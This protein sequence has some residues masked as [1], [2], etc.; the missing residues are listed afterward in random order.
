MEDVVRLLDH[1]KIEKAHV[2]GYSMGGMIT[3]KLLTRHPERVWSAVLG[4]MGWLRQGSPLQQVW[5]Q[6]PERQKAA[7]PSVCAR[8]L[9]ALAVTQDELKAI[10]LPVIVLVGGRDPCRRLYVEPLEQVRPDWPVKV[11]PSAGHVN[12]IL[13]PEFKQGIKDWL[14][15]Q[16]RH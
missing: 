16:A 2:V 8:S 4:G 9:G 13:Q 6:L 15:K 14:E 3:L 5:T 10:H 7:T 1:L 11:I 12:C